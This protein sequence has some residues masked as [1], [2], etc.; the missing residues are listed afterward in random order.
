M[1]VLKRTHKTKGG[2]NMMNEIADNGTV[3]GYLLSMLWVFGLMSMV[4]VAYIGKN[5]N[6]SKARKIGYELEVIKNHRYSTGV[7]N[8]SLAMWLHKVGKVNTS[9]KI[10]TTVHDHTPKLSLTGHFQVE[11]AK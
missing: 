11:D 7:H 4:V 10:T 3:F 9:S 5:R 8:Q 2:K 1:A 6:E